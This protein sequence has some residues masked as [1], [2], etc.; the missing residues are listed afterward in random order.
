MG[1]DGFGG[2]AEPEFLYSFNGCRG[3]NSSHL[4]GGPWLA[5]GLAEHKTNPTE[6][7]RSDTN[8]FCSHCLHLMKDPSKQQCPETQIA[9]DVWLLWGCFYEAKTFPHTPQ[10]RTLSGPSFLSPSEG[11]CLF[12]S[13]RPVYP[14]SPP[15]ESLGL[16]PYHCQV[17]DPL[18]CEEGHQTCGDKHQKC[19]DGR[20]KCEEDYQN[21]GTT[22][23]E[24]DT[25]M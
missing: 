18:H 23:V 3:L 19:R 11:A 6:R 20:R 14:R 1:V 17:E 15:V 24:M 2:A 25:A 21:V 8:C 10:P 5:Q 7:W 13:D 4:S 9:R 22:S 12:K 16:L